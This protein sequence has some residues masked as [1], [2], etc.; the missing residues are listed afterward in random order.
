MNEAVLP[1]NASDDRI[2]YIKSVDVAELRDVPELESAP[3][4]TTVYTV[5]LADGRRVAIVG[6]RD[7]AFVGARQYNMTPVSVH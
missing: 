7:A 5:H 2:V 1:E 4:G 3:D 6:D